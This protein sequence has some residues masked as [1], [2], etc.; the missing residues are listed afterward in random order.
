MGEIQAPNALS[1]WIVEPVKIELLVEYFILICRFLTH[2]LVTFSG[3]F[4]IDRA[5]LTCP[6]RAF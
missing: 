2:L 6:Y 1:P 5:F 3:K 4:I